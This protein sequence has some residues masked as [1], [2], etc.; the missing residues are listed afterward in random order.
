MPSEIS[1]KKGGSG[2]GSGIEEMEVLIDREERGDV[3]RGDSIEFRGECERVEPFDIARRGNVND[4]AGPLEVD[5]L[6]T[7]EVAGDICFGD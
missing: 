4:E 2:V 7:G 6:M 5:D 1:P 3:R